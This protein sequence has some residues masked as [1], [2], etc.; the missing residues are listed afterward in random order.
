MQKKE[1]LSL[2]DEISRELCLSMHDTQTIITAF[3]EKIENRNQVIR[4][5]ELLPPLVTGVPSYDQVFRLHPGVM[6]VYSG[7]DGGR[8]SFAKRIAVSTKRQGLSTVYFD[9]ENKLTLHDRRLFETI[10]IAHSYKESGLKELVNK[11]LVDCIII[12]T[13]TG[14]YHTSHESFLIK[15]KKKVPYIIVLTQMRRSNLFH[16]SVPAAHNYVLSTAH[17]GIY[18][19]GKEKQTIERTSVMRIVYQVVKYEADREKEGY[20]GSFIIRNN[21][22]DILFSVYDYVK[23][24]GYIRMHGSKKY[25]VTQDGECAIT[26]I[27]RLLEHTDTAETFIKMSL[28]EMG[29]QTSPE[30]Y[31]D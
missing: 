7:P 21:I 28:N 12:D 30:V 25:L 22:V 24:H 3:L 13:I 20:R 14:I 27:T 9:V 31:Y 10:A 11:G 23:S 6:V 1:L 15:L 4:D 19:T 16:R 26:S 29:L 8:T 18:L 2:C 5:K 17:T